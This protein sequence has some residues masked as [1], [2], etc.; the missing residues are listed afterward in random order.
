MLQ[1][2][3]FEFYLILDS[4]DTAVNTSNF[5]ANKETRAK[6]GL[7][8]QK[9]HRALQQRQAMSSRSSESVRV[10]CLCLKKK[11]K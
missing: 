5:K 9:S 10:M 1:I 4:L 3:G 8:G 6:T 2:H 11:I 7:W